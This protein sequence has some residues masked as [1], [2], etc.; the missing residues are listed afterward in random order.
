MIR[1]FLA[2]KLDKKLEEAQNHASSLLITPIHHYLQ[3][4]NDPRFLSEK[5]DKKMQ[6]APILPAAC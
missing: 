2:E 6:E 3:N 5:L 1:R 4:H